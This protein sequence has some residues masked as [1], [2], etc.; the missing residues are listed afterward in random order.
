MADQWLCGWRV[1]SRFDVPELLARVDD[2]GEPDLVIRVG[3]IFEHLVDGGRAESTLQITSQGACVLAVSGVAVFLIDATSHEV[4]IDPS[5][6]A[7]PSNVRAVLLGTVLGILCHRRELLPLHASCVEIDG[8]AVAFTGPSGIGKSTLAGAFA[9]AGHRVIADD[10]TVVDLIAANGPLVRPTFPRLKLRADS[11]SHL[12]LERSSFPEGPFEMQKYHMPIDRA[13]SRQPVRLAAVY[14]LG[15]PSAANEKGGGVITGMESLRAATDAVFR[16]VE[17]RA[18]RGAGA[19]FASVA[20]LGALVPS[21]AIV[22]PT[23]FSELIADVERFRARH[24][25]MSHS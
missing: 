9:A 1:A 24:T 6:G 17:A 20:R 14:H 23:G 11:L 3:R 15:R 4:T 10:V 8:V 22:W 16:P 25:S 12:Q 13:F 21:Y 19:V 18:L 5:P 2:D 7:D